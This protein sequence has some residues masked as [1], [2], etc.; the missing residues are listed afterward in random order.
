MNVSEHNLCCHIVLPCTKI[1][2][3]YRTDR[4]KL[5]CIQRSQILSSQWTS[6][7]EINEDTGMKSE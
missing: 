1:S 6:L 5:K 4:F 7:T 3:Q 2:F